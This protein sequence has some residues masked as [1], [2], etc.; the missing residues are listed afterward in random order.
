M[1]VYRPI[2]LDSPVD[3]FLFHPFDELAQHLLVVLQRDH[4]GFI[5]A[6]PPAKSVVSA[7]FYPIRPARQGEEAGRNAC[8]EGI[9]AKA[10]L[11][12]AAPPLLY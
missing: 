2:I 11:R 8:R 3:L 4:E 10:G 6:S 1:L 9:P 7:S 5:H 12:K